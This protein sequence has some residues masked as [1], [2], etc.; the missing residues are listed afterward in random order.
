[1]TIYSFYDYLSH[2]NNYLLCTKEL[3]I[4]PANEIKMLD[5]SLANKIYLSQSQYARFDFGY[6]LCQKFASIRAFAKKT[7]MVKTSLLIEY[8]LRMRIGDI[9]ARKLP[10][11]VRELYEFPIQNQFTCTESCMARNERLQMMALARLFGTRDKLNESDTLPVNPLDQ[12]LFKENDQ[13]EPDI[14]Q[15]Y[16]LMGDEDRFKPSASSTASPFTI[17]RKGFSACNPA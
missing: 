1:M 5:D 8:I 4:F 9:N 17:L 15:L 11:N 2:V 12:V 13:D 3:A 14:I 6:S 10:Y 16:K 7:N